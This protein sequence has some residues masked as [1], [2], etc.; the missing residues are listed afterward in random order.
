MK[1]RLAPV[2]LHHQPLVDEGSS[3]RVHRAITVGH[4]RGTVEHQ[5]VLAANH[6]EV[7]DGCP[8]LA[9]TCSQHGVALGV[10]CHARTAKHSAPPPAA[11]RRAWCRPAARQTQVLADQ[12]ADRNAIDLEHTAAAIR[13]DIEVAALVEHGVVGQLTL[14][15][16]LLDQAVTQ[17]AG[18]VVDHRASRLRPADHGGDAA[19]GGSDAGHRL[20]ALVQEARAQQQV[21]RRVAAHRQLGEHHQLGAVLVARLADHLDDALGVAGDIADREVELRHRDADR[22]HG[23]PACGCNAAI[24]TP[25]SDPFCTAKGI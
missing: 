6:V 8:A 25:G 1:R 11:H 23:I 24:V 15:V 2:V 3:S 20:L 13:I 19:A 7:S 4:H 22:S 18:G 9:G 12:Q 10:L 5:R 14:A 16:G 17:H 21:F